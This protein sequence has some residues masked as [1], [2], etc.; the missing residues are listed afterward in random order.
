MT[1]RRDLL[2]PAVSYGA[3]DDSDRYSLIRS[4][5]KGIGFSRFERIVRHSPFSLA[6]WCYFLHISPRTMQRYEKG[7]KAFG[8]LHSE[9]IVEI[10]LLYKQ[11]YE[12]FGDEEKFRSWLETENVALGRI[13]P[14]DLLDSSFGVHLLKD[15][16]T[17]IEHGVLA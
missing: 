2:D 1:K 4:V 12:V 11:G 5:R 3:M 14:K 9:K 8:A 13:K 6:D 15:E 7:N 17:R 16:L 10:M